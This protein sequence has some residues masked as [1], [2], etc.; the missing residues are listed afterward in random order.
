M[1]SIHK[2]LLAAQSEMRGAQKTA[3]NPHFRSQYADLESVQKACFPQLHKYGIVV[4]QQPEEGTDGNYFVQTKFVHVESGDFVDNYVPILMTKQDAQGYGSG[5][6]YA[7]RYGLMCLA[8]LAPTDDDGNAAC[9]PVAE[10]KTLLNMPARKPYTAL[11]MHN[12][13]KADEE[14]NLKLVRD[15]DDTLN[16][17]EIAKLEAELDKLPP[18][19][20]AAFLEWAGY[21]TLAEIPGGAFATCLKGLKAKV[22]QVTA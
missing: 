1:K 9:E 19:A 16:S 6:T 14:Q 12:D 3:T 10:R 15:P 8:G 21:G 13:R 22:K 17:F 5:L 20:R 2:A 7:R 11:D 18:E 4:V